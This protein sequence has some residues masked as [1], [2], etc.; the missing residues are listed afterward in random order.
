[1]LSWQ[2]GYVYGVVAVVAVVFRLWL[3]GYGVVA[4]V[5]VVAGRLLLFYC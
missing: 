5:A 4:V 2:G 1:M 3:E